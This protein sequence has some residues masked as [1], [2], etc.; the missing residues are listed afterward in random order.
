MSFDDLTVNELD[1]FSVIVP[2]LFGMTA[3]SRVQNRLLC[4][5]NSSDT[6]KEGVKQAKEARQ[7]ADKNIER[8]KARYRDYFKM[9]YFDEAQFEDPFDPILSS[10]EE[11]DTEKE[12]TDKA[13]KILKEIL[14][15]HN[16]VSTIM[17]SIFE[18]CWMYG[19][20]APNEL[21]WIKK[22]DRKIWFTLSQ[23]GRKA[24]FVEVCGAWSHYMSE[25]TYGF[26]HLS[27][28]INGALL[29]L[30]FEMWKTHE[31]YI[32]TLSKYDNEERWDK[33]V[34]TIETNAKG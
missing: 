24:S 20:L 17:I 21:K 23:C 28:Q 11:L 27:P 19:V 15:R 16:Y 3:Q 8:F 12:M 22:H 4:L 7:L 14:L 10:F 31:N 34:P 33:L 6:S 30:D 25:K 18:S 1:V 32:A 9:T 13:V 2:Q 26:K 29:G 5:A